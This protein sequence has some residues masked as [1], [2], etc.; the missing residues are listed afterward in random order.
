M[1]FQE[2]N[3]KLLNCYRT[4]RVISLQCFTKDIEYTCYCILPTFCAPAST[5]V[6]Y[7]TPTLSYN[8]RF[9]FYIQ[10]IASLVGAIFFN[11]ATV[12]GLI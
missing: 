12:Y 9:L 7:A 1:K 3:T 11:T 6:S 10:A 8:H 5:T 4:E 2:L